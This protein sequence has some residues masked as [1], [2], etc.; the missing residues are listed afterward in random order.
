MISLIILFYNYFTWLFTGKFQTPHINLDTM[1]YICLF[2]FSEIIF[3]FVLVVI[4]SLLIE[5]YKE[6]H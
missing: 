1:D 3:E 6:N 4:F 5:K 2:T